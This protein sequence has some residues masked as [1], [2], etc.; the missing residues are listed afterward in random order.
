MQ[1]YVKKEK[2]YRLINFICLLA[3]YKKL[4]VTGR[5][6][7]TRILRYDQL[8]GSRTADQ[9]LSFRYIDNTNT[10]FH[11]FGILN[12]RSSTLSVSVLVGDLEHRFSR[13]TAQ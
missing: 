1:K 13:D 3:V 5:V 11:E 6:L 12:L 10:L 4:I 2:R 9:R 8:R 7:G